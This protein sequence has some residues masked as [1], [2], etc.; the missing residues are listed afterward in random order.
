MSGQFFQTYQDFH[1]FQ[2]VTADRRYFRSEHTDRFLSAELD[3]CSRRIWA[4]GTGFPL[5]RARSEMTGKS[6]T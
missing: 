2:R 3:S 5:Y 4:V 6:A 1:F